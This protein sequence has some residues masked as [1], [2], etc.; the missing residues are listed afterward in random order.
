MKSSFTIIAHGR[1]ATDMPTADALVARADCL[2]LCANRLGFRWVGRF[3]GSTV[4]TGA[5]WSVLAKSAGAFPASHSANARATLSSLFAKKPRTRVVCPRPLRDVD[6]KGRG[7]ARN[8][9]G[10]SWPEARIC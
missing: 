4:E 1:R 6:E 5:R 3:G 8:G 10:N 7:G 2:E 9:A